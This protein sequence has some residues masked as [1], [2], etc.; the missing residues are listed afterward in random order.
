MVFGLESA[1]RLLRR[2]SMTFRL[3]LAWRGK[4]KIVGK[5]ADFCSRQDL[6]EQ[7]AIPTLQSIVSPENNDET[8][9]TK[10]FLTF[11]CSN[12]RCRQLIDAMLSRKRNLSP[13]LSS[14]ITVKL[15]RNNVTTRAAV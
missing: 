4:K 14:A 5:F 1:L 10:E 11:L 8:F 12:R 9:V 13:L 6:C 2:S 7:T 3:E 15:S